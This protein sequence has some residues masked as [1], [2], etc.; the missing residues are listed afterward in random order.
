MTII[1]RMGLKESGCSVQST[2]RKDKANRVAYLL[3]VMLV[4]HCGSQCD[5]READAT[6]EPPRVDE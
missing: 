3:C 4:E 1:D 2:A 5:S 6:L